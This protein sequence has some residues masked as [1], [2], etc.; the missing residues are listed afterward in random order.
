MG[1]H[2]ASVYEIKFQQGSNDW[3]VSLRR[4][5]NGG[6]VQHIQFFIDNSNG[7][8]TKFVKVRSSDSLWRKFLKYWREI[9]ILALG[10]SLAGVLTAFFDRIF[11]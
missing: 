6:T 1:S 4:K 2:E 5:F 8:V 9:T 7:K 10:T 3:K 11:R